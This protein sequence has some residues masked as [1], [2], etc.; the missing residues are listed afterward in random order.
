MR[1]AFIN[2]LVE[3][4][5][6]DERIYLLTADMGFGLVEPFT[7]KYPKRFINVGVA[8]QNMIG[9][10]AGLALSG[11]IPFVYSIA[12]FPTINCLSQ[13][14]D[15]VCYHNLNVNIVA[16]S[17]GLTYGALGSTHHATEDISIMRALPNMA[18]ISPADIVEV[19]NVVIGMTEMDS[20]CYLRLGRTER[21]TID[22]PF[23]LD[24]GKAITFVNGKDVTLIATGWMCYRAIQ[25]AGNLHWQDIDVRV[26]N[27]HTIKPIDKEII[28]RAARETKSIITIEEHNVIGGLGSAVAEVLAESDSHV[29]FKRMGI[30]DRFCAEVDTNDE[31]LKACHLTVDDIVSEV[32]NILKGEL[33]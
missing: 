25:S 4:A 33:L 2:T 29:K 11:K 20:P 23:N 31:L 27:M 14:R 3:L 17:T 1:K 16:G 13:I 7:E 8:E 10:A 22:Y 21:F 32:S 9:V 24:I 6:K 15:D 28:L 26:I 12:N 5:S 18:V 30:P 19:S